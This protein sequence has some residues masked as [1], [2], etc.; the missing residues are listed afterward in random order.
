MKQGQDARGVHAIARGA[1]GQ[2]AVGGAA[3]LV[4]RRLCG[5]TDGADALVLTRR[6]S[7]G[8]GKDR[9]VG[10]WGMRVC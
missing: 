2:T 4:A 1:E 5:T 10:W 6:A 3:P 9:E 8:G 7:G